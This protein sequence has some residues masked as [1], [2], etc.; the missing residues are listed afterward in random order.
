M[1]P[2]NEDDFWNRVDF[3]GPEICPELGNCWPWLGCT[4]GRGYGL[5]WYQN[6]MNRAAR[7]ALSF[8][9]GEELAPDLLAAPLCKNPACCRPSH[10]SGMTQKEVNRRGNAWSGRNARKTHCSAGHEL[11]PPDENGFRNCKEC[12]RQRCR[13]CAQRRRTKK[14]SNAT[15]AIV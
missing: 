1:R 5:F 2:N 7:L 12:S 13:E 14:V 11:P 15:A 4:D 8:A 10:L 3:A 6:K 9:T